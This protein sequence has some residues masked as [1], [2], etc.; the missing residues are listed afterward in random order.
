MASNLQCLTKL[1]NIHNITKHKQKYEFINYDYD[2]NCE[3]YAFMVDTLIICSYIKMSNIT[4]DECS[5]AWFCMMLW[6]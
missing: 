1:L 5:G 6:D 3:V 2:H 4:R